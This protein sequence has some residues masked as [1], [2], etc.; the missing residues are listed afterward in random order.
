MNRKEAI[1][2]CKKL[3]ADIEASGFTKDAFLGTDEGV[4]WSEKN[5]KNDCPLC[6]YAKRGRIG[7]Y[8]G[9]VKCP[10]IK[11]Y[12]KTCYDLGFYDFRHCGPEFYG[13]IKGLKR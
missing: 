5:Y 6:D 8:A 9:C 2:E 13:F 10:L 7:V 3:W 12:R 11:Q 1:R 4:K